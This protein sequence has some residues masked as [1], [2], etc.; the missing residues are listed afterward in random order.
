MGSKTAEAAGREDEPDRESLRLAIVEVQRTAHRILY[1]QRLERTLLLG[2]I[3]LIQAAVDAAKRPRSGL[4]G[5]AR[6]S[7]GGGEPPVK[8]ATGGF[9]SGGSDPAGPIPGKSGPGSPGA[10][11]GSGT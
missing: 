8:A 10:A 4:S 2:D 6:G 7:G 1:A 9:R 11:L 5:G 3:A